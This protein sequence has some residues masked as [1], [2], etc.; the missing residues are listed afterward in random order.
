MGPLRSFNM[1]MRIRTF[2]H[3][4]VCQLYLCRAIV[5]LTFALLLHF[6]G[7]DCIKM[8]MRLKCLKCLLLILLLGGDLGFVPASLEAHLPHAPQRYNQANILFA[9]DSFSLLDSQHPYSALVALFAVLIT[10]LSGVILLVLST[11]GVKFVRQIKYNFHRQYYG[12]KTKLRYALHS[13]SV[14]NR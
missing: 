10:V 9:P 12:T 6:G 1:R 14:K 2:A 13:V 4:C 7:L 8:A 3:G 11:A 5:V